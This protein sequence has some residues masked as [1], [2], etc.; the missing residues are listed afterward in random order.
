LADLHSTGISAAF[1]GAGLDVSE[2][3]EDDGEDQI[4]ARVSFYDCNRGEVR[5]FTTGYFVDA[6]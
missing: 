3:D 4:Y 5:G 2:L 6:Y 1:I